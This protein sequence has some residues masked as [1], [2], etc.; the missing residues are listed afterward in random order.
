M[1]RAVEHDAVPV[2]PWAPGKWWFDRGKMLNRLMD[3]RKDGGFYLGDN[4]GRPWV[5]PV[6]THLKRARREGI[7]VL[8]GSDPLPFPEEMN[9]TATFGVT[10]RVVLDRNRPADC[11]KH[12]LRERVDELEPFGRLAGALAFLRREVTMQLTKK[13]RKG[14]KPVGGDRP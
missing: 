13:K 4:G 12:L 8:P 2:I 3:E 11:V 10:A 14:M 7:P 9:R 1:A 5:W 6:P